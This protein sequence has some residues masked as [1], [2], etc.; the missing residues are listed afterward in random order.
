MPEFREILVAVAGLTPQVIT[1][2]LLT[3]SDFVVHRLR[4]PMEEAMSRL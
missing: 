4:P 1:E 3:L 2:T